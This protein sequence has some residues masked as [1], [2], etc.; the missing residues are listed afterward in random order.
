MV[1]PGF[2]LWDLE[3]WVDIGYPLWR[4]IQLIGTAAPVC[5][6]SER[7]QPSGHKF[8]LAVDNR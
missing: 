1:L 2:Q 8:A 3:D 4:I 5:K 7:T 6:D